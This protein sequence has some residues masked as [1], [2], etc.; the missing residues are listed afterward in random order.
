VAL[1]TGPE[2]RQHRKTVT[3]LFCDVTGSTALGE[4][5]DPESF[6]QVMRR[7]F[8][9]ARRVIEQHGGTV[10][11]FIG[12]AVMAV[13]GIPVL[14]EDDALRAVRAA[15]G[16]R[17]EIAVLNGELEVGFGIT[18]RVRTGVNTGR[19]IT[20][21]DELAA[22]DAV[23]L[24]A[25]LE[26]VAAP[27]EIVIGQQTWVLARD[28]VAAEPLE[29]LELKG[30]SLP[31]TAYRL[32]EVR[33]EAGQA[34]RRAGAP[35]VG[36]RRELR[37]L[38]DAFAN[39]VDER[40]CGLFTV[41]GEAGVGKSRL[42][43]EFLG[44]V[45]AR[46]LTGRCLS[47]G[48]G[49]T[50]SPVVSM[51]RQLLDPK[52]GC[53]AAAELMNQDHM[54]AAAVE[55]LLGE[56]EA[57]T[58][59]P[60]IAWAVRRLFE[61]AAD[62]VPVI[63][64]F[65]DLHWSEPALLDLIEHIVDFS[66]GTSI[67]VVCLARPEL[68][69]RRPGW[70]GGKLNTANLLLEPL[71]PAEAAALIDELVPA[72]TLDRQLRERVQAAAA[73]NPLFVEEMLAL[74]AESD[75]GDLVI[76]PTIQAL[77]AA[78][79]DQLQLEE[80]TVLGCGAVEGQ[81]FHR[82]TVQALAPEECDVAGRL[83]RLVQKDLVR[84]EQAVLPGE[85]AF[86]F[87]H[88]LIRDAAYHA[89]TKADRA[90][91]HERFARW[92]NE[93]G[94]GLAEQDEIVGYHLEQ[95]LRYR[96]ELGAPDQT[97]RRLAADAAARLHA[98][99]RRALVRGDPAAAVSLLERAEA[100]LL[101]HEI[102]LPLQQ[103]LIRAL[104]ESG[105]LK[106]AIARADRA[107][108]EC[109]A[110]R[111]RTGE[112]R[113]RLAGRIWRV[114]V[115]PAGE[116]DELRALVEEAR[117]TIERCSDA[118]GLAALDEAAGQIAHFECRYGAAFSAFTRAMRYARQAG[119]VWF[120]ARLRPM[121]ASCVALGPTPV[122]EA[123]RWLE[124]AQGPN[125]TYQ[126]ALKMWG[127]HLLSGLGRFDEARALLADCRAQLIDRGLVLW[128]AASMQGT[129]ETEILAGDVASA[130][131]AARQGCEQLQGLGEHAF[132]ST[133]ACQLADALYQLG[134]YAESGQW[135]LR[136]LGLGS[137]HDLTTQVIGL[138]VRSK[139]LAHQGDI[140]A[141][142]SLAK[143]A[144]ELAGA[145]DALEYQGD[146]ALNLAEVRHLAGDQAGAQEATARAIGCYRRKGATARVARAQRLA[147]EWTSGSSAAQPVT[148]TRQRGGGSPTMSG[149]TS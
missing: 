40:S 17:A 18:L 122:E 146:A 79:L 138:G 134:R 52:R 123:L 132:L 26:Q 100:L 74:I 41:L 34:A 22:G 117:S 72:G 7:Y 12:D 127:A 73:G 101:P 96:R 142:A 10:E 29:P 15:A 14:H 66:R 36:R 2:P 89:L 61:S 82:G 110:A 121:A 136:G 28:A 125:A 137:S 9:T 119:D 143:Q 124:D 77:L 65:D 3:V 69:D 63:V 98:A 62:L 39:V 67:Y 87:R 94:V 88:L 44:E 105:R 71:K 42:A 131:R 97:A 118:A 147:A 59:S 130:E 84:P 141:A 90:G 126:P 104:A 81:S 102:N 107:A 91:L 43:A 19:V 53:A 109:A 106:D 25:R 49:I 139:L 80:R 112:L 37:M 120:E 135:A 68:L 58:S 114:S 33:S 64:V 57:V 24:A 35:L 70:G 78:R 60:E 46:V 86:R 11:K 99:G 108:G 95:A 45:D 129:W 13:F 5:L 4:R 149:E 75:G 145:T 6:R 27:G 54:V 93:R 47:Y 103:G 111:D 16:L 83:M 92:L 20:D 85:D 140:T 148:R 113:A 31:V 115:D 48:Q 30:K 133:Q 32:L 1:P 38:G 21:T 116:L 56:Q 55:V 50:Y 76:P 51:V 144:D 128:A 8:D 23:N